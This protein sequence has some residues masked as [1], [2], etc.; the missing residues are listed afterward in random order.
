M[1]TYLK[2]EREKKERGTDSERRER[3]Q[4]FREPIRG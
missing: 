3:N 2:A 1:E 4:S